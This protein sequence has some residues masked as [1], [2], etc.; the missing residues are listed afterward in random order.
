MKAKDVVFEQKILSYTKST[1]EKIARLATT[2]ANLIKIHDIVMSS[3]TEEEV[4]KRLKEE[5]IYKG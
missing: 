3:K 2:R 4:V 5:L 1:M